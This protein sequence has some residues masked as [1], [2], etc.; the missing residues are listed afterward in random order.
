MDLHLG[1]LRGG[2][3]RS[4]FLLA[5]ASLLALCATI[6]EFQSLREETEWRIIAFF[7]LLPISLA[8]TF[9]WPRNGTPAFR[10]LEFCCSH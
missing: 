8:L 9:T 4:L 7:L 10:L 2:W 6:G 1:L 3:R 5:A